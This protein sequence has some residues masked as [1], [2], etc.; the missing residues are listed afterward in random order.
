MGS[1]DL[2]LLHG[3]Q[4]GHARVS[5]EQRPS[6]KYGHRR[7]L[8]LFRTS[9][10]LLAS[11]V[12]PV[13]SVSAPSASAASASAVDGFDTCEQ[14][15]LTP[16][17][18]NYLWSTYGRLYTMYY[19]LGG[20]NSCSTEP[21]VNGSAASW[22]T[23]V[24]G[25]YPWSF[26]FTWYGL[27]CYNLT[28]VSTSQAYNDGYY[29]AGQASSQLSALGVSSGG[30]PIALDIEGYGNSSCRSSVDA[31]VNG[32]DA[33]GS[34]YDFWP[35][36]YGSA[37]ASN[38]LDW[39]ALSNPPSSV[40]L[41]GELCSDTSGSDYNDYTGGS[42]PYP[43][44]WTYDQVWSGVM[45][46]WVSNGYWTYDQ[47]YLQYI[48]ELTIDGIPG[49]NGTLYMD[50]DCGNSVTALNSYFDAG[51]TDNGS[52]DPSEDALCYPA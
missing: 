19:Y 18:M 34:F 2:S 8:Q 12:V 39:A 36:V 46:S 3:R 35:V 40:W 13:V 14:G 31:Y 7:T 43:D 28:G 52:N 10:L 49:W 16:A 27:Q 20:E 50:I 22:L 30:T 21:T 1:L 23:E 6:P 38:P 17:E 11:I 42:P 41:R 4:R 9:L 33:G 51:D 5:R 29:D 44:C 24:E 45:D 47:R 15:S 32:W 25:A 37:S 48:A 26:V